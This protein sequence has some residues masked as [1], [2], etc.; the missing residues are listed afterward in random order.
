[1]KFKSQNILDVSAGIICHQVNCR[2]VMGSGLAKQIRYKWPNVYTTYI[3]KTEWNL[4]DCQLVEVSQHLWVANLAGQNEFGTN[5]RHT[6]Y[7][8]LKK[9]LGFAYDFAQNGKLDLYIPH[10]IGCGLG[11]GDWNVVL[12]IIEE[13]APEATIC[14]I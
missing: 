14:K 9:A 7:N 11:G 10:G 13:V 5:K 4:G 3:G 12:K 2:R 8:A 6:D 1:M